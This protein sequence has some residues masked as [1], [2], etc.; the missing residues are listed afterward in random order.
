M[1]DLTKNMRICLLASFLFLFGCASYLA[2]Q[3]KLKLQ[4]KEAKI[5]RQ[6][7]EDKSTCKYYGFKEHVGFTDCLMNLDLAR[8]Q[9]IIIRKM[10]ECEAVRRDNNQSG[11]TGFWAGVLMGARE[12]LACNK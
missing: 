10:L 4:R 9:A 12:N 2:E 11:A 6:R 5:I 3:K 7:A 8:K 1:K